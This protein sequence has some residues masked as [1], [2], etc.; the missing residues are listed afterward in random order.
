MPLKEIKD[1]KSKKKVLI[2]DFKP[3]VGKSRVS[4]AETP[5]YP[6]FWRWQAAEAGQLIEVLIFGQH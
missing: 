1:K 2:Q 3:V 4:V 5:K 6:S